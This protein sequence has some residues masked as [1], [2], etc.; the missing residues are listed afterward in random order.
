MGEIVILGGGESGTGAALLAQS[1]GFQVFV[2]DLGMIKEDYK[3]VLSNAKIPFEEGGHTKERVLAAQEIVKSP[4]IPDT[5]ALIKQLDEQG[6]SVVDEIEF[7][8]RYTNGKIIGITG[9]NGKTTTTLLTYETLKKA[10]LNV[11][12]AGNIGHSMAAQ[13]VEGDKDYWVLELSSFQLDRM[14]KTVI[15]IAAIINITPDHLDRYNYEFDNYVKSKFRILQNQ[16]EQDYFIYFADDEVIQNEIHNNTPLAN[17][18]GF[19]LKTPQVKGAWLENEEININIKGNLK[20]SIQK[21]ALQG[22]HN[23]NNTMAASIISQVLDI[24]KDVVRESMSDF[25]NVEHRLENFMTISHVDYINDSKATN[26]NSTWYALESMSQPTAWIVGG[27]DKGN[28]YTQLTELVK[29]KVKFIIALGKDVE[30]I[31]AAFGGLVEVYNA[32]D[33]GEAVGIAYR[34]TTKGD[35]VLLSPCCASFDMFENY[36]QRGNSFKDLVR[37]L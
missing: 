4:G 22:K 18:Y 36:E 16:T 14:Y 17:K 34:F 7:A 13:I 19:S 5:V 10:G 12:L 20:M 23:L 26:V 6:T 32:E 1:K 24:R 28:D 2:S 29:D 37:S 11:G 35:A 31:H 3:K 30:K 9:S 15:H 25:Q 33:M 21:L 27:V 8:A